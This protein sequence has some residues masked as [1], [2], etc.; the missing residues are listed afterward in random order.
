MNNKNYLNWNQIRELRDEGVSIGAHSHSHYH[1]SDLSI[2]EV[3]NEIE[4]SNN[5]FLKEDGLK[6]R[7]IYANKG[8]I[9]DLGNKKY[10]ELSNGSVI[11]VGD[12]K[13]NNFSFDSIDFNLTQFGSKSTSFPKIQEFH[14]PEHIKPPENV[15]RRKDTIPSLSGM[16]FSIQKIEAGKYSG[17]ELL[18]RIKIYHKF[19]KVALFE[20]KKNRTKIHSKTYDR[21][22]EFYQDLLDKDG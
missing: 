22:L 17:K 16:P 14:N 7:V 9:K 8:F 19:Y 21:L 13:N 3:R 11:N 4:I 1:M 6:S 20:I 12:T 15:N 18:K 5:I 2:D 10:L